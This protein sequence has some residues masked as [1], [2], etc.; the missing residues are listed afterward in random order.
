M[1]LLRLSGGLT[2][3][4]FGP[5]VMITGSLRSLYNEGMEKLCFFQSI[6]YP[7]GLELFFRALEADSAFITIQ[8]LCSGFEK[9]DCNR[10]DLSAVP[11]FRITVE[12]AA[13]QSFRRLR[14]LCH[15]EIS[16]ALS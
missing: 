5:A 11:L 8:E 16:E 13:E 12:P 6:K 15:V 14:E 10:S 4:P 9:A 2:Q 1:L 3:L 7:H